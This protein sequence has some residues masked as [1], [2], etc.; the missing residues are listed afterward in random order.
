[1]HF[2]ASDNIRDFSARIVSIS[3]REINMREF[4]MR[5]ISARRVNVRV[6]S[7]CEKMYFNFVFHFID[8]DLLNLIALDLASIINFC[9]TITKFCSHHD[10]MRLA[11]LIR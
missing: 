6:I 3:M 10:T 7:K 1:M 4:S 2:N 9:S 5:R 11:R 8:L